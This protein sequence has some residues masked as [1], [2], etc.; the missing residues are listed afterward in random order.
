MLSFLDYYLYY[1]FAGVDLEKVNEGG[2]PNNSEKYNF[3][4][5]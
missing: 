3:S 2:G 5:I 4:I 1:R